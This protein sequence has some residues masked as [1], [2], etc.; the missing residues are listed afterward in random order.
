MIYSARSRLWINV[1]YTKYIDK[2][3]VIATVYIS[4]HRLFT[5]IYV[6]LPNVK[7]KGIVKSK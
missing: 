6:H 1:R 5:G 4:E 3:Q 7:G 2:L